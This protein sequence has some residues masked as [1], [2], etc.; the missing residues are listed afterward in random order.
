VNVSG[1]PRIVGNNHLVLNFKQNGSDKVFDCIGFNMG[2]YYEP[3]VS[4]HSD[5]DIVFTIDKTTRD[6]RTYPQFRL[7][8]IIIK[9]TAKSIKEI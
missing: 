9:E 8:D 3:I 1:T 4:N 6:G 2:Q 5:Y 7:K